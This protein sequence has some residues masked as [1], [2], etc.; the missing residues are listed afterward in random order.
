MPLVISIRRNKITLGETRSD[1]EEAVVAAGTAAGQGSGA[2]AGM[3][4]YQYALVAL[5]CLCNLAD[6]FDVA[7]LALVAPVL[8]KD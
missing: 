3:S 2:I 5:C 6:G 1:G 8:S 4:R 7:S